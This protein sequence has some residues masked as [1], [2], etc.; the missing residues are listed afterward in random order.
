M[1]RNAVEQGQFVKKFLFFFYFG[2]FIIML[3]I[4]HYVRVTLWDLALCYFYYNFVILIWILIT[5][6]QGCIE[7]ILVI[8]WFYDNHSI[9]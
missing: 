6:Y 7:N 1:G 3:D 8:S 4:K 2:A 9:C 5:N